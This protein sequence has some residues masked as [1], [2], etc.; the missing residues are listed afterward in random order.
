MSDLLTE[1]S[2][3]IFVVYAFVVWKIIGHQVGHI[4][5]LKIGRATLNPWLVTPMALAISVG[6]LF[7]IWYGYQ[8]HWY[9]AVFLVCFSL[10]V[11]QFLMMIER[12]VGLTEQASMISIPGIVI[13]PVAVAWLVYLVLS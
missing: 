3:I 11:R 4:E 6:F 12:R 2:I 8:T 1:K 7:L 5:C 13:V 10:L 9:Y